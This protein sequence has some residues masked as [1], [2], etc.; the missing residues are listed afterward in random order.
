MKLSVQKLREKMPD[1]QRSMVSALI[2]TAK[3]H[4]LIKQLDP[5]NTSRKFTEY[6]PI[7]A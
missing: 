7:W 3:E 2:A 4:K 6:V 5:D 1:N